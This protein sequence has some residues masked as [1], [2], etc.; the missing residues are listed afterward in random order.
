MCRADAGSSSSR[1]WQS[2]RA[3]TTAMENRLSQ[4]CEDFKSIETHKERAECSVDLHH[5]W[6]HVQR[7]IHVISDISSE[8][9]VVRAV[10]EQ[11]A[12]RHCGVRE[13]MNEDRFQKSFGV[14]DRVA[15]GG[16]AKGQTRRCNFCLKLLELIL[17]LL[18]CWADGC[19]GFA[20]EDPRTLV[21]PQINEQRAG[22]FR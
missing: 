5:A 17:N 14:M 21:D 9:P 3:R 6:R 13:A 19:G 2:C 11:I 12:Q 7:M 10:L 18:R 15:C 8:S 16:D 4:T 20:I 22:V 1:G